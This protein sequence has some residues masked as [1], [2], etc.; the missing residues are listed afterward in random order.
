MKELN[1]IINFL[2]L[3]QNNLFEDRNK[4]GKFLKEYVILLKEN[5]VLNEKYQLINKLKE[6]VD[7]D[8]KDLFL[9]EVLN[10]FTDKF[11]T[12]EIKESNI[13]L[14]NVIN[15]LP[16][17][18]LK[19]YK[20]FKCEDLMCESFD[21]LFNTEV[22]TKNIELLVKTK[23]YINENIKIKTDVVKTE[24]QKLV[25]TISP[26]ILTKTLIEKFNKKFGDLLNEE[27]KQLFK[28]IVKSNNEND[29]ESLIKEIK[30]SCLTDVNTLLSECNDIDFKEKLLVL[31]EKLLFDEQGTNF[32]DKIT[33]LIETKEVMKE[34]KE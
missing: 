25:E 21:K 2:T 13:K 28:K 24:Q 4:G 9:N 6:G 10:I 27:Q 32:Y 20:T 14:N 12:K 5:K 30:T 18:L 8:V 26:E 23:S 22:N 17:K 31:K 7:K 16:S 19:E 11:T 15:T 29:K 1:K 3:K 34:I 33:K